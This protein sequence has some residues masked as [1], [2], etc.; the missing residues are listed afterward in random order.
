MEILRRRVLA[1]VAL[2]AVA[3][4]GASGCV[5]KPTMRLNHAD[6]TGVR[7]SFPPSLGVLMTVV[8]DV[9]NPNS[10]DVAVRAVR[11]TVVLGRRYSMPVTFRAGGDGVWMPAGRT[12]S[13]AVPVEVPVQTALAVLREAY[14]SPVIPYRF[15]GSADVTAT[16][17]FAI[18]E[19]DYSVDE[20]GVVSRAQ[21]EA[22]V[23]GVF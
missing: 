16:R 19:D 22:V 5:E 21:V 2:A 14:T 9:H 20:E 7:V 15:T 11:G 13:V 12:T 23:R 4:L 8:L 18:E 1:G 10:Y 17:T 3:A 6:V